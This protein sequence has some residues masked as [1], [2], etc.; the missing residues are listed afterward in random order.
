MR[1]S[2]L[3]GLRIGCVPYLNAKPLVWD[4]AEA[5]HFEVP[6]A[7]SETFGAGRLDVALLPVFEALQVPSAQ[8]VEGFAIGAIGAVFSVIVVSRQPLETV[9]EIVLDPSSRT[10]VS[11]L[12]ILLREKYHI[13]PRLVLREPTAAD[14]R[15]IIGDPALV[16]RAGLVTGWHI[17][18]LGE[19]WWDWTGLPFV[20]AAWTLRPGLPHAKEV[21]DALRDV[22]RQGLLAREEIAATQ[23][24][25]VASLRYLQ[26]A[27]HYDFGEPEKAGLARYQHCLREADLLPSPV[28]DV[29]FI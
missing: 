26:D 3:Q 28:P 15:L 5:V 24:D 19:A 22:A 9:R 17:V 13:H 7:L 6:S 1:T 21:A 16:F 8:L 25:P 10:S 20:F 11:L 23:K 12:R 27:I 29:G 2:A 4:I 14:A 18:D